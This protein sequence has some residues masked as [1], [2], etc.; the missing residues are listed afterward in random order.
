MRRK[1]CGAHCPRWSRRESRRGGQP[2]QRTQ[3][4]GLPCCQILTR[5]TQKHREQGG[6]GGR[7]SG[8]KSWSCHGSR[9]TWGK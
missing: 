3:E 5:A 6:Q 2:K 7:L 8:W 1:A 4:G 9:V